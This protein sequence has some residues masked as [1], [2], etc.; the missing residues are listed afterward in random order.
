MKLGVISDT[1]GSTKGIEN[2]MKVLKDCDVIFHLGDYTNDIEYIEEIYD[3][4]VI[5]V[6]GNCDFYSNICEERIEK[7]GNNTIFLTHGDKYGVKIN[8]FKLRYKA[9][10]VGAN[11][12]LYGHSHISKVEYEEGIWFI[13]PGSPSYPRNRIKTV[14]IIDIEDNNIKPQI[15]EI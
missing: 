8:I 4:K 15:V 14:C 13:N 2:A 1:H 12:V 6:R 3:G 5:A 7:I 9:M 10:E 11:I